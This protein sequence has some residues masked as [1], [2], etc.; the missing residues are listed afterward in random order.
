MYKLFYDVPA[1]GYRELY[2]EEQLEKYKTALKNIELNFDRI[3]DVGCG[4]GLLAENLRSLGFS[5]EYIGVDIDL[6]RVKSAEKVHGEY[7][8]ADAHHL[9]FRDKCFYISTSFTV[10]HLLD[11]KKTLKEMQRVSEKLLILTLLK[12]R[13]DL[14]NLLIEEMKNIGKIVE[15]DVPSVKDYIFII[16]LD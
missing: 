3:L 8:I 6:E 7:I 2:G 1:E 16:Y 10:I 15:I 11:L 4:I 14:K 13:D 9:P 12:K 5:G